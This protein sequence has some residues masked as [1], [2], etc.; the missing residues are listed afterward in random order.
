MAKGGPPHA[1]GPELFVQWLQPGSGVDHVS[2]GG[3]IPL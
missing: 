2:D 1:V 3:V